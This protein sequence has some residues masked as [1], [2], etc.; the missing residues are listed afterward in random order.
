MMRVLLCEDNENQLFQMAK[1]IEDYAMV[2]DNGIEIVLKATDPYE[3]LAFIDSTEVDCF[4]LDIDLG[5][6]ITGMDL[7][8]KIRNKNPFSSIIFVTTHSDM[9]QMTF[10]YHVEALDFIIKDEMKALKMNV[11]KA[12]AKAY[13]KYCVIG[14]KDHTRY[15]QLK[16]GEFV[17]NIPLNDILF[18]Q[19]ASTSHKIVIHTSQGRFEF[20]H[21]LKQIEQE[22]T[23]F[24]RCHQSYVV[25]MDNIVEMNRK[26]RKVM[27]R[28][29]E[30]CPVSFRRFKAL[31]EKNQTLQNE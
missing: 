17:K 25:N 31:E 29:G 19:A 14:E 10:T 11:I 26:E 23:S 27:M 12:L 8:K 5:S 6:D 30:S 3:V 13:E 16:I 28:N 9:L 15:Y 1:Y 7:A 4:F 21:T 20:Y 24:F 22:E 2:E 18:F